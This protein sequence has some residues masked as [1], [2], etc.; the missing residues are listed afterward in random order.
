MSAAP[1]GQEQLAEGS[2]ISHLLEL[3]TRLMRAVVGVMLVFAPCAYYSNALYTLIEKPLKD[4]LPTGTPIIATNLTA[5][6]MTPIKL[7]FVTA[8][9]ISMPWILYQIWAFVAPG[10]YKREKRFA[11]PLLVSSILLFYCGMVFAYFVVFPLMFKFLTTT[12]PAG[13]QIM[14]DMTVYL[15]FVLKLFFVFGLAFEIPVATVLLV[16][17][18]LVSIETLTK[19]R[20]YVVLVIAIVAAVITPPDALSMC[21]MALP[22]YLLFEVGI[23]GS[24]FLLKDKLAERKAQAEVA[25]REA[26]EEDP[27]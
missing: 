22:M 25:A 17:T 1:E 8:I 27:A 7:A 15:D 20:G 26:A 18:G 12:G 4:K 3:R 19:N 2:L 21:F 14:A 11:V 9:F 13:V 24:R 6:F 23:I 10:L 5:P 16:W